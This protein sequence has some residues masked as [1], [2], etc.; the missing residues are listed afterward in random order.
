M[1]SK[2]HQHAPRHQQPFIARQQ[3]QRNSIWLK[4]RPQWLSQHPHANPHQYAN[5][6]ELAHEYD[7]RPPTYFDTSAYQ[8]FDAPREAPGYPYQHA[9]RRENAHEYG[10]QPPT[11]FDTSA[12]QPFNALREASPYQHASYNTRPHKKR[13][14]VGVNEGYYNKKPRRSAREMVN[15]ACSTRRHQGCSLFIR[16]TSPLTSN[17]GGLAARHSWLEE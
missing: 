2:P 12:Y 17:P 7:P 13:E 16:D 11:Y 8:P 10:P 3:Q 6:G 9:N 1:P 5:R 14:L 4:Q 15:M